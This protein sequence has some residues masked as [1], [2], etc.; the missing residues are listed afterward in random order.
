MADGRCLCS[1]ISWK[2]N[3]VKIFCK[4]TLQKFKTSF[5][6]GKK[7]FLLHYLFNLRH[8]T[9]NR[10]KQN[11]TAIFVIFRVYPGKSLHWL[12]AWLFTNNQKVR[13]SENRV[14]LFQ[15]FALLWLDI[16]RLW[17][18]F[19][20][21]FGIN[22]TEIKESELKKITLYVITFVTVWLCKKKWRYN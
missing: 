22:R 14:P 18:I 15:K 10:R 19:A 11:L 12:A 17:H 6:H 2:E 7:L 8:N 9:L 13:L 4:R 16:A 21:M 20:L 3:R 1:W 5:W